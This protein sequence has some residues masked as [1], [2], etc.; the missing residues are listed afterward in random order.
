MFQMSSFFS[1]VAILTHRLC[2]DLFK[3]IRFTY[4]NRKTRIRE[5][6]H[7]NVKH[8]N[9]NVS[10]FYFNSIRLTVAT[11]YAF[12]IYY[13]NFQLNLTQKIG[14]W[15]NLLGNKMSLIICIFSC[16][17]RYRTLRLFVN[18][19]VTDMYTNLFAWYV[20]YR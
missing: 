1:T 6:I 20:S 3:N 7:I 18:R 8:T 13:T 9:F 12:H 14:R 15:N 10:C 4:R 5:N 17:C 19:N 2:L 11:A 16:G